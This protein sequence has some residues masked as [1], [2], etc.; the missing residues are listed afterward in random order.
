MTKKLK[1]SPKILKSPKSDFGCTFCSKKFSSLTKLINHSSS[2]KIGLKIIEQDTEL[3]KLAY[4]L[5][6][7]SFKNTNRKNFSFSIFCS[8]RDYKFFIELANFCLEN[9]VNAPNLYMEYCITHKKK[10]QVWKTLINYLE[11]C[12]HQSVY[13]KPILGIDRS[14]KYLS[15]KNINIK[16]L[17]PGDFLNLIEM[18][19]ISPWFCLYNK[20]IQK[21]ML[22][23]SIE[24]LNIYNKTVNKNVWTVLKNKY[25]TEHDSLV[26]LANES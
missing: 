25:I 10:F 26:K 9:N 3:G 24:Q 12:K 1:S 22:K 14:K 15:E 21:L 5:W 16:M 17:Q 7:E 6:V 18:Y 8:H 4:S 20:D 2:C 23:L 19:R 11:Y 13:E